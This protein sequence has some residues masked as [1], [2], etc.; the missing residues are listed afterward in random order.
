MV[1]QVSKTKTLGFGFSFNPVT[2]KPTALSF[3]YRSDEVNLPNI[4][5]VKESLKIKIK[6]Q[7]NKNVRP[8]ISVSLGTHF[9]G[10]LLP[11][12]DYSDVDTVV[13]GVKKRFATATPEP[14]PEWFEKL[15]IY[16]K[17][18]MT[19]FVPLS[20]NS[21]VSVET[22]LN[23]CKNYTASRKK[24]LL[25]KWKRVTNV[26][27]QRNRIVKSFC[28]DERYPEYK[29][30]RA[31]N[32]RSDEF[33]C[34]IGPVIRLIEKTFFASPS[35]IKK[36]PVPLRPEALYN[37]LV[38]IGKQ[39]Q[40]VDYKAMESHFTAKMFQLEFEFYDYMTQNLPCHEEFMKQITK[41]AGKNKCY[42]KNFLVE[43]EASRMSGE[44]NTSLGN[45][46]VNELVSCFFS[47]INGADDSHR[48]FYEGDDSIVVSDYNPTVNDFK[49]VGF[50]VEMSLENSLET[51]SFCGMIFD[52]IDL[53]NVTNPLDE[54]LTFGWSNRRYV[55][56]KN[57]VK[58]A[59]IRSKALSL[60]YQYPGC[61]I[62]MSLAKYGLRIT[63]HIDPRTVRKN[64][65]LWERDQFDEAYES[66]IVNKHSILSTSIGIRTR[67]LV[68]KKYGIS[69]A[70]QLRT[71]RY[72][73]A[74]TSIQPLD[75]PWLLKV[76]HNDTIHYYDNYVLTFDFIPKNLD[77]IFQSKLKVIK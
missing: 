25:D 30:A 31:I 40:C 39:V 28:K 20:P 6:N 38:S 59:L 27:D 71:E 60:A 22:W 77:S 66:F 29:H 13:A 14:D 15:A 18:F 19:K 26:D 23:S 70:D 43:V 24:E 61:P 73:D 57:T 44:M 74:L 51:A 33:K 17:S 37:R 45:T 68:E 47:H 9:V 16:N 76:C 72:L 53:K 34:I 4:P 3:G 21:D 10:A 11:G 36:V 75:C 48:G 8:P 52:E 41:I 63:K 12:P 1:C 58:L 64:M 55:Q 7:N 50:S 2:H 42:F 56:S 32:S 69:V 54:L 65:S 5:P 62:L 46:Y 35:T 67:F 49:K